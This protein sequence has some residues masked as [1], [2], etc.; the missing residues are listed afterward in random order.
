MYVPN[1][2]F[3]DSPEILREQL[4]SFRRA[5]ENLV[6]E[7]RRLYAAGVPLQMAYRNINL[8]ELQY[9]YRVAN[10]MPDGLRNVHAEEEERKGK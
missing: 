2:G 10:N 9:W 4:A 7:G 1:H 5:L 3:V 8:G 6:S